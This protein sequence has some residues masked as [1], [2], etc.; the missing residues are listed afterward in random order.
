MVRC[1]LRPVALF[2]KYPFIFYWA[3]VREEYMRL[4]REFYKPSRKVPVRYL[5]AKASKS[6]KGMIVV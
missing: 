2:Y 3:A 6:V 1:I 4:K 5:P